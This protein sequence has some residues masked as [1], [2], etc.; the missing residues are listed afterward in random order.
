M[1]WPA[2][3]IYPAEVGFDRAA[4]YTALLPAMVVNLSEDE[5]VARTVNR[6]RTFFKLDLNVTHSYSDTCKLDLNFG[7][8]IKSPSII[9]LLRNSF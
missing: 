2:V 9:N 1:S 6:N 7:I 4:V 3:A 8:I 5:M